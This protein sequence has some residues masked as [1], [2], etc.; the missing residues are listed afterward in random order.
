VPVGSEYDA[1]PEEITEKP[2]PHPT[3]HRAAFRTPTQ[4]GREAIS[5]CIWTRSG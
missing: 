5:T 4:E 3:L 1:Q 2:E